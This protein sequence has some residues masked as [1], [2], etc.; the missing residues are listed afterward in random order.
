MARIAH[1]S[2]GS[3]RLQHENPPEMQAITYIHSHDRKGAASVEPSTIL[4][5]K[6]LYNGDE[7]YTHTSCSTLIKQYTYTILTIHILYSSQVNLFTVDSIVYCERSLT[8]LQYSSSSSCEMFISAQDITSMH[9]NIV[10]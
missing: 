8:P 2:T 10:Y 3:A 6:L 7:K 4:K 9:T 1:S 5:G